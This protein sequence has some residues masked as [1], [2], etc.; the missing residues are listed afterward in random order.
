MMIINHFAKSL[1]ITILLLFFYNDYY[2][3][4]A[5]GG[6]LNYCL[7][8]NPIVSQLF[9]QKCDDN[10]IVSQVTYKTKSYGTGIEGS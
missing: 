7:L 3:M 1:K 5:A 4:V 6:I 8:I 10:L 9:I 2:F